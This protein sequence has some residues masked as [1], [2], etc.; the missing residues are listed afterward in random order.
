MTITPQV[1]VVV[2][3]GN[4]VTTVWNFDFEIPYQDDGVTVA[5]LV[6][7]SSDGTTW[8]VIDPMNYTIAGVDAEMGGTVTYPL[9]GSP[10]APGEYIR[11][12]RNLFYSQGSAFPNAAFPPRNIEIMG[13]RLEMQIQQ[14]ARDIDGSGTVVTGVS[15]FNG[16]TGAVVQ[17]SADVTGALGYTP[18]NRAGDTSTGK[19]NFP[20]VIAGRAPVNFGQ[21][22]VDPSAPVN[23]DVWVRDTGVFAR[24]GGATLQLDNGGS[25]SFDETTAFDLGL[26]GDVPVNLIDRF[27]QAISIKDFGAVC[28]G[29]TDDTAA[30]NLAFAAVNLGEVRALYIPPGISVIAGNTTAMTNPVDIYGVGTSSQILVTGG[31]SIIFDIDTM[32]NEEQITFRDFY[33]QG[34]AYPPHNRQAMRFRWNLAAPANLHMRICM[35]NVQIHKGIRRGIET[36]NCIGGRFTNVSFAGD[37]YTSGSEWAWYCHEDNADPGRATVDMVWTACAVQ[38]TETGWL[39]R[40][41]MQGFVWIGCVATFNEVNW[42]IVASGVATPP[43]FQIIGGQSEFYLTGMIFEN[44]AYLL[45]SDHQAYAAT[46]ADPNSSNITLTDCFLFDIHNNIF[47]TIAATTTDMF[48]LIN[49]NQGKIS[50]NT[51]FNLQGIGIYLGAG[52]TGIE[53]NNTK[54]VSPVGGSTYYL[55]DSG[56]TTNTRK[57]Q[58]LVGSSVNPDTY[59]VSAGAVG[60]DTT[61][62]SSICSVPFATSIG[63]ELEF[64]Y[65]AYATDND[66]LEKIVYARVREYTH[67][68]GSADPFQIIQFGNNKNNITNTGALNNTT[69]SEVFLS[70]TA[71]GTC[72][73]QATDSVFV[74]DLWVGS[75][76]AAVAAGDAQ[77]RVRRK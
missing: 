58:V 17:Q 69:L 68:P 52:T 39:G 1:P 63:D 75:G 65:Y 6:E 25:G 10:L 27:N 33:M 77:L 30:W 44:V 45:I 66:A 61:A 67:R 57:G 55:D 23:G 35:N 13:D 53:T 71:T 29:A 5:A 2:A 48:V 8:G 22:V 72:I 11:I 19:Q 47:P 73:A 50:D 64:E 12:S 3:E 56:L 18:L 36:I 59:A 16:R 9:S 43:Y 40:G 37:G 31:T 24:V 60:L 42:N 51:F 4:N 7:T 14:L 49:C 32:D 70:G 34:D 26:T 41:H 20:A 54:L 62:G 21:G 46:G 15:S 74:L 76:T 38:N 28:D